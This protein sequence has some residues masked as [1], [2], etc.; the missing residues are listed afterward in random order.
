MKFQLLKPIKTI[1]DYKWKLK[2]QPLPFNFSL[3]LE[4]HRKSTTRL[5]SRTKPLPAW[6]FRP[7]LSVF[8]LTENLPKPVIKT[9]SQDSR[10]FF[11][12]S[13][14]DSI[15]SMD[16]VFEQPQWLQML[17]TMSALVRD[18]A[19]TPCT[20]SVYRL[21]ESTSQAKLQ[22]QSYFVKELW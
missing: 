12:V 10:V 11:M 20:E 19:G 21:F 8:S 17:S 13:R 15:S 4:E 5:A 2:P 18:I 1:N 3:S 6:G 14:I 22:L 9:C 7:R 16:W